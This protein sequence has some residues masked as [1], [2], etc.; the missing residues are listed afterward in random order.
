MKNLRTFAI[1]DYL[2]TKK[3]CSVNELMLH[4][5]VSPATIHRDIDSL[6]KKNIIQKVHGGVA[7]ID[8][9]D[10]ADKM[11]VLSSTFQ[12]RINWNQKLK[13]KISETAV[14]E[15]SDG[16]IIFLDSSTTVF[17]L[18]EK[19][20]E[21]NFSSL[22][23]ITNSAMIIQNFYKFPAHYALMSLGGTFDFQLN[24]FLGQ[25]TIRELER[26]VIS[27]AFISAFGVDGETVTT[28]HENHS[29]LLQKVV[30]LAKKKYLLADKSKFNRA[31]LFKVGTRKMFDKIISD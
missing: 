20:L 26:M 9:N 13:R 16:D 31:G 14:S 24:A 17:F 22:T 7:Y 29:L 23:I 8:K 21:S 27:K 4:F 1:V 6:V 28:N 19:L 11:N 3:Y 2:K 18:A 12:E 25:A 5:N 10:A 15:I 30:A